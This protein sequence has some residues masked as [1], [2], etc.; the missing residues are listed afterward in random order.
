MKLKEKWSSF[1]GKKRKILSVIGCILLLVC[2]LELFVWLKIA[3]L[4]FD[5]QEPAEEINNIETT[6]NVKAPINVVSDAFLLN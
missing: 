1:S 2:F 5:K 6:N 3:R 4:S